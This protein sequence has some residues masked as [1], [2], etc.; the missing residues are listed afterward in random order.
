MKKISSKLLF[1]VIV[2]FF[3]SIFPINI[4]ADSQ[5]ELMC[6]YQLERCYNHCYI[7]EAKTGM[8]NPDCYYACS[9]MY[10]DCMVS[11]EL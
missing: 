8:A 10:Y 7:M 6:G 4:N 5:C 1:V 2:L 9:E 3:L 11:C